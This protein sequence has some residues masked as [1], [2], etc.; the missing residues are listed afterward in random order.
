M[1]LYDSRVDLITRLTEIRAALSKVRSAQRYGSGQTYTQRADYKALLEEEKFVLGQIQ[2]IDNA[3][4][5]GAINRVEFN[6]AES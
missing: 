2:Q 6:N 5:G 3:T 1:T 4:G